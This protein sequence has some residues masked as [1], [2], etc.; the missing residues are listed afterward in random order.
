[1]WIT[2]EAGLISDFRRAIDNLNSAVLSNITALNK[3]LGT[4]IIYFDVNK[5]MTIALGNPAACGINATNSPNGSPSTCVD[6][7]NDQVG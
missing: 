5:W 6:G 1:M 7:C 3:D 4:N 2:K